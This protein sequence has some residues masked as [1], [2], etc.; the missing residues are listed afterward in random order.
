MSGWKQFNGFGTGGNPPDDFHDALAAFGGA[1]PAAE[2]LPPGRFEVDVLHGKLARKGRKQTPSFECKLR[3]RDGEFAG[4]VLWK[5][6][7]LSELAVSR[8]ARELAALNIKTA[9]DLKR[10]CPLGLVALAVVGLEADDETK[11]QRNTVHKLT[12]LRVEAPTADTFAPSFPQ[13]T[14]GTSPASEPPATEGG[15]N[16]GIPF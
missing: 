7:W 3:V 1:A 14:G 11:E 5:D 16:D 6:Y 8:S 4:R 12:A 9:E 13:E 15:A 10:G 2:P